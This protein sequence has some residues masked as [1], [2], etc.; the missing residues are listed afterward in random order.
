MSGNTFNNTGDFRGAAMF[1]GST[2]NNAGQ[3]AGT[4]ASADTASREE[5][6]ALLEQLG[7]ALKPV[8]PEKVEDAEA[9]ASAAED[10]VKEAAKDKPNK[11]RL[12]TLGDGLI[13]TAKA[14]G[15]AA[16]AALSPTRW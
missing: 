10:L 16:P 13:A 6:Q 15:A 8:P 3:I 4:M 14:V 7:E 9:T 1:Q 2:I 11:S 5:L 12:R